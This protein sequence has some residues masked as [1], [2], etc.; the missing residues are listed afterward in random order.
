MANHEKNKQLS[1]TI[2]LAGG[3]QTMN[4][5]TGN[6][7]AAKDLKDY[8]A[9]GARV[10]SDMGGKPHSQQQRCPTPGRISQITANQTNNRVTNAAADFGPK[11]SRD[12]QV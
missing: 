1:N 3:V 8:Q 11:T 6:N 4:N 7:H 2:M 5:T 10:G 12:H 9:R